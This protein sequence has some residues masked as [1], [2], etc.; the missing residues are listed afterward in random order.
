MQSW[1][2]EANTVNNLRACNVQIKLGESGEKGKGGKE[3]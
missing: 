1:E 2:K 3:K